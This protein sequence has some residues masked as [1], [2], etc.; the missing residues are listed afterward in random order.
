MSVLAVD[1]FV[2]SRSLSSVCFSKSGAANR[3]A[4]PPIMTV[5]GRNSNIHFPAEAK[6][7]AV[8]KP[9]GCGQ[10]HWAQGWI[11]R[12]WER[13]SWC[14]NHPSHCNPSPYS[15]FSCTFNGFCKI[16][17][18][19]DPSSAQKK[20]SRLKCIQ[21]GKFLRSGAGHWCKCMQHLFGGFAW[22][23]MENFCF[24]SQVP[25]AIWMPSPISLLLTLPTSLLS[26]G[27]LLPTAVLCHS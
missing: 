7:D 8:Q 25:S 23:R 26:Q 6:T 17:I 10:W 27:L 5:V 11:Q 20:H 15:S 14:K 4:G 18:I 3:I 1:W 19:D 22:N 21:L 13:R 24:T 16:S 12:I 9:P 2:G